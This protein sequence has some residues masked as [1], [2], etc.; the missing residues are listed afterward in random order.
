[1]FRDER[2]IYI[3]IENEQAFRVL[4]LLVAVCEEAIA[5]LG[6]VQP[7]PEKL[8]S[9]L[10]RTHAEA[11]DTARLLSERAQV[12]GHSSQVDW[13]RVGTNDEISE[14]ALT[15]EPTKNPA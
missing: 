1:M 6:A 14:A 2:G 7:R 4:T 12:E 3:C 9:H 11:V 15:D 5:D 8:I 10:E 13:A